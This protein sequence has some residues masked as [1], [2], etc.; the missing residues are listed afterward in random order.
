VVTEETLVDE[1]ILATSYDSQVTVLEREL[2]VTNR[3]LILL[4][5]NG[6]SV[7][8]EVHVQ[9]HLEGEVPR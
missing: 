3:H 2:W 1:E 4:Q 8:A 7:R 5:H 9:R 6:V